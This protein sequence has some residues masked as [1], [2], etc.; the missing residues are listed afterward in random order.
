MALGSLLTRDHGAVRPLR[1][2]GGRRDS[3]ERER[4]EVIRVLTNGATCRQSCGDG[5]MIKV[6]GDALMER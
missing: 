4:E 5:H 2:S 1:G 6:T 3:S